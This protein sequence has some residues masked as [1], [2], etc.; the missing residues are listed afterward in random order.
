MALHSSTGLRI[1]SCLPVRVPLLTARISTVYPQRM[2]NAVH[3][4]NARG[5]G[6]L[7]ITEPTDSG[8]KRSTSFPI[9]PGSPAT[10]MGSMSIAKT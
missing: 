5:T 7:I 9:E 8:R 1:A 4:P 2:A 6:L 10:M 3:G